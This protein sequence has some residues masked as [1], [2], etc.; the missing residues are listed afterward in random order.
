MIPKFN[1][2]DRVRHTE[3][4][5]IGTFLHVWNDHYAF[6]IVH[7]DDDAID[8]LRTGDI[9]DEYLIEFFPERAEIHEVVGYDS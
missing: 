2:G 4:G 3:T 8:S 7:F 9:C 6:C 1:P 5:R